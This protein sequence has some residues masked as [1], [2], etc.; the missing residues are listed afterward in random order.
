MK[1]V[2]VIL[3][4]KCSYIMNELIKKT[5]KFTV[6]G[7]CLGLVGLFAVMGCEKLRNLRVDE[8]VEAIETI[9]DS[10]IFNDP[11]TDLPWLKEHVDSLI[12]LGGTTHRTIIQCTYGDGQ[13]GFLEGGVFLGS[14]IF[15]NCKGE[16]LCIFDWGHSGGNN[17]SNLNLDYNSWYASWK[18]LWEINKP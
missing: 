16:E 12:S 13:T 4:I 6:L 17:C 2:Y 9:K 3:F 5:V 14:L 18:L 11:L 7:L 15:Y 1:R 8:L 10:C